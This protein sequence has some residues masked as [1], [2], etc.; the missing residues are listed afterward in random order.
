MTLAE[1]NRLVDSKIRMRRI[2]AQEKASYDYILADL[3]GRS[4]GRLFSSSAKLPDI[5]TVYPTLFTNEQVQEAK[6][7][8]LNEM[9]ALRFKQFANFHN[10]RFKGGSKQE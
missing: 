7:N 9:S 5:S 4:I 1:L 6:Q 10:K 3:V 2:E 8:K